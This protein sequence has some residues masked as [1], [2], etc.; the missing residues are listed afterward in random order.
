M[1]RIRYAA[2]VLGLALALAACSAAVPETSSPSASANAPP[3]ATPSVET[4][5][6]APSSAAASAAPSAAVPLEAGAAK[7]VLD[8]ALA[9]LAEETVRIA[10]DLRSADPD[11]AMPPV[12]GTGQVSFGDPNQFRFASPGWPGTVPASEVIYDGRHV[13]SRG[14]DTPYLP[15]DTWVTFDIKPGTV[16][17]A[18][19]LRQYGDYSLVL[20]TPLAVTSA[21]PAGDE[22]I[23]N[24]HVRRYVT[25]VDIAAARSYVPESL[26]AAYEAHV[27]AFTA[28][29]VPLTHE[30]EVWVDDEG[31]VA[32]TRYE[33]ELQGQAIDALVVSYDFE[34][35]GAPMEAA[36]PPGDEVLTVDEARERYQDSVASPSP[37]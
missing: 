1:R 37:G 17:H 23:G 7:E 33:Q 19:L 31:H 26:L 30:V 8:A 29:G 28:A 14:R 34:D 11:N 35:Y 32:R 4:L 9:T 22:V 18:A 21:V 6:P 24:R 13:Y 5:M 2:T 15:E 20:V 3:A 10:V 12:T 25:Q 16:A 27:E 36:P